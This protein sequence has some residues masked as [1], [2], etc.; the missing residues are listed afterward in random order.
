[1][2]VNYWSVVNTK[3]INLYFFSSRRRHTRLQGDWS[4]D[5]CSSDLSH[6]PSQFIFTP[7]FNHLPSSH[8][9]LPNLA[10]YPETGM[11]PQPGP[12]HFY[13]RSLYGNPQSDRRQPPERREIHGSS[14]P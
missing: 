8:P 13:L 2:D 1:M 12:S 7:F 11:D 10:C 6:N 9:E 4:S 5:V 14:H 3:N